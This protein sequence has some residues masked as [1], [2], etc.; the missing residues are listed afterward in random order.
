MRDGS[1]S[2]SPLQYQPS[3]DTESQR[4]S[5]LAAMTRVVGEKG[6]REASVVDVAAVAGVSRAIFREHFKSKEDCFLVAYAILVTELVDEVLSNCDQG[7]PWLARVTEG[8]TKLVDRFAVD[9]R[10]AR[11]VMIE[12][13]AAGTEARQLQ[14]D[15]LARF[16][17][18][19]DDGRELADGR[20]LPAEISLMAAGAVAG[21]ICEELLADR[22]AELTTRLPD[23]LFTMLVPY[24]GPQA[25]AV[26]MQRVA[27]PW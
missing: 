27:Q 19:L 2:P 4:R 24:L 23:L 11:T 20:E 26:E 18:C 21:L 13:A 10:L 6:Y 1:S 8:L 25:A 3:A 17:E 12:V 7:A 22:G 14:L 15:A 5:I 9:P 16:A